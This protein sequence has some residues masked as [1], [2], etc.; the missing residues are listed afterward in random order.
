MRMMITRFLTAALLF[1][2]YC[3]FASAQ[4]QVP[5]T[6]Q[7]PG[8][9]IEGTD[10][11]LIEF[12]R[13]DLNLAELTYAPTLRF[14]PGEKKV[15]GNAGVND[16]NGS[17]QRNGNQVRFGRMAVARKAGPEEAMKIE[18]I[19]L[20]HLSE[21]QSFGVQGNRLIL[22]DAKKKPLFVFQAQLSAVTGTF[23]YPER[24]PL[25]RRGAT[26]TVMLI[27]VSL[28]D[29][30]ATV[31]AQQA[32]EV[33]RLPVA[34]KLPY[35]YRKIQRNRSYSV[36]ATI[37]HKGKLLFTSDTIHPVLT[38]GNSNTTIVSLKRISDA[39]R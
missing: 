18:H 34:F 30:P 16:I 5:A 7:S 11:K 2:T 21:V 17:Y 6:P 3:T 9:E 28:A 37:T 31:I 10:W 8:Y 24:G 39:G 19:F 38:R 20:S 22:N 29:A 32:E 13:K 35:D 33:K 12:K 15:T 1:F 25:P 4:G 27:D 26:L 23:T 14:H 36:R